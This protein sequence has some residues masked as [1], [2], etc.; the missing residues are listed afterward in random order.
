MSIPVLLINVLFQ[1]KKIGTTQLAVNA[2]HLGNATMTIKAKGVYMRAGENTKEKDI[3]EM[4]K[5]TRRAETGRWWRKRQT[6]LSALIHQAAAIDL[7][8]SSRT[9]TVLS[10]DGAADIAGIVI[11]SNRF[12][13]SLA[14]CLFVLSDLDM[15]ETTSFVSLSPFNLG[16]KTFWV[17]WPQFQIHLSYIYI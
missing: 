13:N 15:K 12:L 9:G 4:Y 8:A 5:E 17:R 14:F 1:R 16:L 11:P 10:P 2:A 6:L 7:T 3:M